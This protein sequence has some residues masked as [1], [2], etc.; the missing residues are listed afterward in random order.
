MKMSKVAAIRKKQ[1]EKTD[2]LVQKISE[3]ARLDH[4]YVEIMN[5]LETDTEHKDIDPEC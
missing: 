3:E 2:P 4:K 1:M 5:Y